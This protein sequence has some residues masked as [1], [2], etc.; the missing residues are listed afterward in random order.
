MVLKTRTSFKRDHGVGFSN[1]NYNNQNV[2][3]DTTKV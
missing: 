2:R 3:F 1:I